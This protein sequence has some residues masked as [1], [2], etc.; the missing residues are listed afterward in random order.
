MWTGR[1]HHQKSLYCKVLHLTDCFC[2][3]LFNLRSWQ[4][5]AD[6]GKSE[7]NRKSHTWVICLF[8]SHAVINSCPFFLCHIFRN[9]PQSHQYALPNPT[10]SKSC[11][12]I[13]D[14][15]ILHIF[16]TETRICHLPVQWASHSNSSLYPDKSPCLLFFRLC[17]DQDVKEQIIFFFFF[18]H[19]LTLPV[20]LLTKLGSW[21]A[22]SSSLLLLN[23]HYTLSLFKFSPFWRS[24]SSFSYSLKLKA[25]G[26]LS[27]ECRLFGLHGPA[28]MKS[29]SDTCLVY[30]D[31]H[32][33][34]LVPMLVPW[35]VPN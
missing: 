22:T 10:R 12:Y 13:A 19:R 25:F 32:R 29:V 34:Q 4:R 6:F 33:D 7:G 15:D 28:I 3:L 11:S 8:S 17:P 24:S 18:L 20:S 23:L 14:I 16:L 2:F 30:I 5:H 9:H 27:S 35:V 1:W 31:F 21:L 26:F